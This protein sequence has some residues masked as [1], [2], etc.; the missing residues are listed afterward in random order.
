VISKYAV[1]INNKIILNDNKIAT[2][3][4]VNGICYPA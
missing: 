1:C 4:S 2:A 3:S